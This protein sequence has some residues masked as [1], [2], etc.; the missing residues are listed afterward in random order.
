M[1]PTERF[2]R[3]YISFS[4]SLSDKPPAYN[5]AKEIVHSHF[6]SFFGESGVS[7]LAFKLVK[8]DAISGRGILR[9]ERSRTDEAI[10]CMACLAGWK[11][12]I[13]RIK[14]LSTSGTIKRL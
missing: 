3:R 4:L 13:A 2:K 10:F 7:S 5:E 9:C 6:L 14:P 11:G 12:A 8:Y 1:K